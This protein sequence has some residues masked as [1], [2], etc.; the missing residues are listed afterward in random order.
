MVKVITGQDNIAFIKK[1]WLWNAT[2][3]QHV[4][5]DQSVNRDVDVIPVYGR[6]LLRAA[7]Q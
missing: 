6:E 1:G 4:S 3:W 2:W 7:R 5:Q